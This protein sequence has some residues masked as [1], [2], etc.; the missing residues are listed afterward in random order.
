MLEFERTDTLHPQFISLVAR[1]DA[2][3]SELNGEAHGFYA[4]NNKLDPEVKVLVVVI[5]GEPVGCGA[6]RARGSR[7]VEIKR[8]FVDP[9]RRGQGIGRAILGELEAWAKELGHERAVLETS[10]RLTP[11]VSLYRGKG[12]EP[13]PSYPPYDEAPDS[14]CMAKSLGPS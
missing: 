11:A 8:M 12:Y 9:A 3:L 4:P 5:D 6:L 10:R 14:V 7:E 13:I 2:F 1:L